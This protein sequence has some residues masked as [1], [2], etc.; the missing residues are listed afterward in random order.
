MR[1]WRWK[2]IH[3]LY[4]HLSVHVFMC[5][6][7]YI[8]YWSPCHRSKSEVSFFLALDCGVGIAKNIWV[9]FI[10]S[11]PQKN[12]IKYPIIYFFFIMAIF[13]LFVKLCRQGTNIFITI[14]NIIFRIECLDIITHVNYG[15][16][17]KFLS[18]R[19]YRSS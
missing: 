2:S 9:S 17:Q 1:G 15:V 19:I 11:L 16:A 10:I 14:V 12:P 8:V 18:L 7:I 13:D 5:L 4:L 3:T 6:Y